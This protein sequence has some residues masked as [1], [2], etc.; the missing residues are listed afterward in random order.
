M[1]HTSTIFQKALAVVAAS[2]AQYR[3]IM[4]D[5][6]HYGT[7]PY[8]QP[9]PE[10]TKRKLRHPYGALKAYYL[11]YVKDLQPGGFA[12]VP[13]GS[14]LPGPLTSAI[15]AYFCH[16]IGNGKV[17]TSINRGKKCIE[18]ARIG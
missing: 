8:E 14:F 3:I 11:P 18:V 12:E 13:W 9:K 7:L 6:T 15:S 5:G 4:P 16:S 1:D 2:G 17:I 10:R